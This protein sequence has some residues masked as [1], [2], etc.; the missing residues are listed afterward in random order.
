MTT[1][2]R[3]AGGWDLPKNAIEENWR[4]KRRASS[5]ESALS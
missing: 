1:S 4:I 3:V 2:I 5:P